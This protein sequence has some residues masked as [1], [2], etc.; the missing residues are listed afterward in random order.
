MLRFH[1]FELFL[2]FDRKRSKRSIWSEYILEIKG[3]VTVKGQCYSKRTPLKQDF[4]K[5]LSKFTIL[6]KKSIIFL[7]KLSGVMSGNW[8][9]FMPRIG[10]GSI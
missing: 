8:T 2:Y 5:P 9:L 6:E 10:R 1:L 3:S 7:I 4:K